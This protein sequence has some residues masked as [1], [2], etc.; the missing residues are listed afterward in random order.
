M[1]LYVENLV[2]NPLGTFREE[3]PTESIKHQDADTT[4]AEKA[5]HANCRKLAAYFVFVLFLHSF[6]KHLLAIWY[7]VL[8]F[9]PAQR[10]LCS[11]PVSRRTSPWPQVMGEVPLLIT[12][13]WKQVEHKPLLSQWTYK[14]FPAMG[15]TSPF[16]CLLLE[17]DGVGKGGNRASTRRGEQCVRTFIKHLNKHYSEELSPKTYKLICDET[18]GKTFHIRHI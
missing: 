18:S 6:P 4:S 2:E 15:K 17:V 8:Q 5:L 16:C 3:G 13:G 11:C 12:S 10:L 14:H 9:D 1:A 7:S